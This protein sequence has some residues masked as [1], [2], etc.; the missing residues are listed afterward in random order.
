MTQKGAVCFEVFADFPT[1]PQLPISSGYRTR[2]VISVL[3]SYRGLFNGTEYALSIDS[4]AFEKIS[5]VAVV[6]VFRTCR[7]EPGGTGVAVSTFS[8]LLT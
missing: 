6:G 2:A 5:Y 1:I 4:V 7:R 3:C 8:L